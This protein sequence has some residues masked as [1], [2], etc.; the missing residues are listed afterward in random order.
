MLSRNRTA[1]PEKRIE[2]TGLDVRDA[3]HERVVGASHA[4]VDIVSA[5]IVVAL[6][7]GM[8]V[9]QRTETL[10]EL[11]LVRKDMRAL[12]GRTIRC[13]V[14][15]RAEQTRSHAAGAERRNTEHD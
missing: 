15:G 13:V 5:D 8:T 6:F 12:G 1:P 14:L 10:F 2:Q 4:A 3:E 9:E 11:E 7:A